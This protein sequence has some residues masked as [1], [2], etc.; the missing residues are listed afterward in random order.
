MDGDYGRLLERACEKWVSVPK[1]LIPGSRY[2]NA[3]KVPGAGSVP[4]RPGLATWRRSV[5]PEARH[6][7][8]SSVPADSPSIWSALG[9]GIQF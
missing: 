9:A 2:R 3:A 8:L 4:R 7:T 1:G 5:R 6:S